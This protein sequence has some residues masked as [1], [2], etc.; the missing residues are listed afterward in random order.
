MSRLRFAA[1]AL[2]AFIALAPACSAKRADEAPAASTVARPEPAQGAMADRTAT[3]EKVA[4]PHRDDGKAPG[5]PRKIIRTGALTVEVDDYEKVRNAIERMVRGAGG[6]V[7]SVDVGQSEG[8][9]GA[10]TMVVR[11]PE[12]QLD[13]A[14]A[15]LAKLGT[16]R[17]EALR[18]ED[19]SES[20]YDLAARLRNAKRLEERMVELAAK[21]GGVK[22]LLEV[23]REIGRVR[24]TIEVM[25][26]QLRGL[27]DR[28]S[29]ATLTVELVARHTYQPYQEP[30]LTA[31]IA[32]AFDASL[33]GLAGA[34]EAL[35]LFLVAAVPWMLPIGVAGFLVRKRLRRRV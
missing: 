14:V 7:A 2:S 17:R 26:G 21:A 11:I 4:E 33:D 3:A 10:A 22:D 15:A 20:Y 16:L 13:A 6:F 29:L 1:A 25:E 8:A 28:A 9:V 35:L 30:T 23:E 27:D 24:E 19:V 31:K 12:S 32:H 5:Q 34:A 18:A